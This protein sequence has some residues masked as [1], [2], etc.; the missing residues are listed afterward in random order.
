MSRGAGGPAR[1]LEGPTK[2]PVGTSSRR[3][4][5]QPG[6]RARQSKPPGGGSEEGGQPSSDGQ[7]SEAKVDHRINPRTGKR[8]TVD[9]LPKRAP[10]SCRHCYELGARDWW[11]WVWKG[12]ATGALTRVPYRCGSIRC[13][14]CRHQEAH[15]TFARLEE[16]S[17]RREQLSE[18]GCSLPLDPTC[19]CFLVLTIDRHGRFSGKPWRNQDEAFKGLQRMSQSFLQGLRRWF[20]KN[21]W[22]DLKV[23]GVCPWVSTT[24]A[25]R[26]GW[27]HV[28]FLLWHPELAGWLHRQAVDCDREGMAGREA[29]LVQRGL[30]RVVTGAGWG[31]QSTAEVARDSATVANY[32]TKLSGQVDG[33]IGEVTKLCQSP[34]DA[35]LRFR[36]LRAGKGF[37][38]PRHSSPEMTGTL[39]RRARVGGVPVVL[40]LHDV[41]S[42]G[43]DGAQAW[44]AIG[45]EGD[46]WEFEEALRARLRQEGK[47]ADERV[48]G[49]PPVTS[50]RDRRRLERVTRK[51][52]SHEQ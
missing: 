7:R 27:P 13:P 15:T 17:S 46:L 19:W 32:V 1:V 48:V 5:T 43:A 33:V 16:A 28:N 41:P 44:E 39:V 14:V 24:E 6:G 12:G 47:R 35:P 4:P 50:W 38:P 29:I 45:L 8:W 37:L 42:D 40:S 25:H 10:A 31:V 3:L 23:G 26:S 22:G 11:I 34:K 9:D 18:H 51:Q 2:G 52:K 21:G 49:L 20:A 36:R 30:A